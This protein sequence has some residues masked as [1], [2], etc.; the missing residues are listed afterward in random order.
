MYLIHGKS[1]LNQVISS[2]DFVGQEFF[3][4]RSV[5]ESILKFLDNLYTID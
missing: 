5:Y 4:E 2:D 1:K 3:L